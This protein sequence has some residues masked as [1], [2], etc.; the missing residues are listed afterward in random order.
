MARR[1][2]K[3]AEARVAEM[4]MVKTYLTKEQVRLLQHATA[5]LGLNIQDY[6]R[7]CIMADATKTVEN[8]VQRAI[9]ERTKQS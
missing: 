8:F 7:N 1:R 9:A 5:E 2:S 3:T 6:V 4:H